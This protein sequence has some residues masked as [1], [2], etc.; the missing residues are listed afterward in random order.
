MYG[1]NPYCPP[2][3]RDGGI[4]VNNEVEKSNLIRATPTPQRYAANA[5]LIVQL[6]IYNEPLLMVGGSGDTIPKKLK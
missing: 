3:M 6:K 1:E 4:S 2:H 5:N